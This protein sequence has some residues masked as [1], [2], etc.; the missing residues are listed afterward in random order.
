VWRGYRACFFLELGTL[1]D[2]KKG[3]VTIGVDACPWRLTR[4]GTQILAHLDEPNALDE[5]LPALTGRQVIAIQVDTQQRRA[6]L[7]LSGD[8]IIETAHEHPGDAWYALAAG[9]QIVVND[10]CCV[11][12][13]TFPIRAQTT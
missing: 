7:L 13:R 2:G 10:E 11:V 4:E 1:K 9:Y 8:T 6:R 5:V 3:E 12:T